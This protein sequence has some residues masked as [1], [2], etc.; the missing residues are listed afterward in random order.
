MKNRLL[1]LLLVPAALLA[2]P[3]D[4]PL[5][6]PFR[7]FL[8]SGKPCDDCPGMITLPNGRFLMGAQQGEGHNDERGP[9]G[10]PLPVAIPAGISISVGEISRDQFAVFA[11]E[12]P[13]LATTDHCSGLRDGAFRRVAGKN[14]REPGFPQAGNHPVVCV[15][16]Q[17]AKHYTRWLSERTGQ[18]YRLPTEAEWE[19]AARARSGYQFWWGDA[20]LPNRVNCLH[21]W[22]DSEYA[23]TAPVGS[24]RSNPFGL[25]DMMGNVWE[26]TEDCYQADAY[27]HHTAYP[28]P[29]PGARDCRRVIRGGSWA[30]NYWSLRASNREAWKPEV[31]L[32]DIGFRVV[33][34]GRKLPL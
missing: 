10:H 30:E 27:R 6:T 12:R 26:W 21:E 24:Y 13:A 17:M 28:E 16:W 33:R 9:G 34:V 2:S 25:F 14:W 20:M 19:Y 31:P 32:N 15:T 7:D 22:C 1:P 18:H 11:A 3:S 29:V 5:Q 4:Y 23:Y 8:T